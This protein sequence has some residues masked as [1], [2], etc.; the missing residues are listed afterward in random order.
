MDILLS[1]I[2][3][4]LIGGF[5]LSPPGRQLLALC[6]AEY[7]RRKADY[8]RN[9]ATLKANLT[10]LFNSPEPN[11]TMATTAWANLQ[12]LGLHKLHIVLGNKPDARDAIQ[13]IA[14]HAD[15]NIRR[16]IAQSITA[17]KCLAFLNT[18]R[19]EPY[20]LA[21]AV[22]E[23]NPNPSTKQFTLEIGRWNLGQLRKGKRP[24]IYDEQAIN[25]DIAARL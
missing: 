12:T 3:V 18:K 11:S 23:A 14:I 22:L 5:L 2:A 19:Q 20:N 21:L 7:D 25:N 9:I 8:Q 6:K 24:T 10:E 16:A 1:L 13:I 17:N 4:L 15:P